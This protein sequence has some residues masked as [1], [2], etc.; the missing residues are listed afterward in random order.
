[1]HAGIINETLPKR[2]VKVLDKLVNHTYKLLIKQQT[3]EYHSLI[4][5]AV[6][7]WSSTT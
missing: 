4:H 2:L 1:M 7:D 6:T 5:P 3:G